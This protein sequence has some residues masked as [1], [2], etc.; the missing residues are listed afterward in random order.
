MHLSVLVGLIAGG[1]ASYDYGMGLTPSLSSSYSMRGRRGQ[2][3]GG[4]HLPVASVPLATAREK[5]L[6]RFD[7]Q[8]PPAPNDSDENNNNNQHQHHH[9]HNNNNNNNPGNDND[10]D[11]DNND[12]AIVFE[13]LSSP[14]IVDAE[15]DARFSEFQI[16]EEGLLFFAETE[17]AHCLDDVTFDVFY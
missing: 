3:L 17:I 4:E 13:E 12:I 9:H 5:F 8:K 1:Y 10:N 14:L 7:K 15:C 11:N 6:A 16:Q 2:T